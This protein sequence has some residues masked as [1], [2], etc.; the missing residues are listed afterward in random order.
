MEQGQELIKIFKE[1]KLKNDGEE[2]LDYKY[3]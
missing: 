2:G 3:F 1:M